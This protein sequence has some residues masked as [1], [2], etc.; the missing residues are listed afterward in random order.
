[1]TFKI[2]HFFFELSEHFK[3]FL[4]QYFPKVNSIRKVL[5]NLRLVLS[6]IILLESSIYSSMNEFFFLGRN[7][8]V[9]ISGFPKAE[10]TRHGDI[11]SDTENILLTVFVNA[12]EPRY[13]DTLRTRNK[14]DL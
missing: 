4:F 11:A 2:V 6:T 3:E 9:N 12:V 13:L 5:T 8:H 10:T 1:M 7:L 14:A